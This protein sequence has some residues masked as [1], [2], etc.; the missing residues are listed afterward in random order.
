MAGFD[1]K[2]ILAKLLT[3]GKG[4]SPQ[5]IGD[6][7]AVAPVADNDDKTRPRVVPQPKAPV[8]NR[9]FE[10]KDDWNGTMDYHPRTGE[11]IVPRVSAPANA[12]PGVQPAPAVSLSP[13]LSTI[14]RPR[15]AGNPLDWEISEREKLLDDPAYKNADANKPPRWKAALGMALQRISEASRSGASPAEALI[16]GA[17]GAGEGII[18]PKGFADQK[19]RAELTK[20]QARRTAQ[21]ER[22]KS[23]I[24][25]QKKVYDVE[26]QRISN[27][28]GMVDLRNLTSKQ[29]EESIKADGIVTP[30]ESELGKTRY[31]MDIP[32]YDARKFDRE[33]IG[34]IQYETPQLGKGTPKPVLGAPI[35]KPKT[36]KE[37]TSPSGAKYSVSQEKA[38]EFDN[39]IAV[40]DANRAMQALIK[41]V[42]IENKETENKNEAEF[43]KA[44]L[45]GE[46]DGWLTLHGAT[47]TQIETLQKDLT[48]LKAGNPRRNA[49][50][51]R[52][53]ESQ[54]AGAI[55][56][57]DEAL[58]KARAAES[59]ANG[60]SAGKPLTKLSV[61]PRLSR[62]PQVSE[63]DFRKRAA[64]KG[65]TGESL[66]NAV[67]K[68]REDK[69]IK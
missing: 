67:A 44:K 55:K 66:E 26:G 32:A 65:L 24:E 40:G 68:A 64:A 46:R 45:Y 39:A 18:N 58:A 69:V 63:A 17:G 59:E 20:L 6:A 25:F 33:R 14:E 21:T 35:D 16:Y 51:I 48:D 53:K 41:N 38:A 29:F 56:T 62:V 15:I 37:Y 57:R 30:E 60:T 31:S 1:I 61:T 4:I 34:G 54:L 19:H 13:K 11:E 36:F 3:G 9:R 43:K 50:A 22:Q 49:E 47:N 7:G 42:E 10:V 8:P 2:N 5:T 28:K 23:E 12:A 27:Q 52:Q